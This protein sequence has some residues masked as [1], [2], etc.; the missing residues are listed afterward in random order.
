MDY[1]NLTMQACRDL[2]YLRARIRELPLSAERDICNTVVNNND[3]QQAPGSSGK[4]HPPSH[5]ARHGLLRHTR[6]VLE[7]ALSMAGGEY[8]KERLTVAAVCHDFHKIKEYRL[9]VPIGATEAV[10]QT[11]PFKKAIGHLVSSWAW[12]DE[13]A[14][15]FLPD[16]L[17]ESIGHCMLAHHGRREWGAAVEPT[18]VGAHVLHAADM[19]SM[20]GPV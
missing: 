12:F 7:I 6:E 5:S 11:L 18:T 1:D 15:G 2:D 16:D 4:H 19:L 14:R 13:H 9:A 20:R 3:F 10:V 8:W 17:R